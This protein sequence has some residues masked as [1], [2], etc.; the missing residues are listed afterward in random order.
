MKKVELLAFVV[1]FVSLS[2]LLLGL[3][4]A[5]AVSSVSIIVFVTS[6]AVGYLLI[7]SSR[8]SIYRA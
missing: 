8:G 5:I 2:G 1:M 4:Q 7:N 6:A 3:T